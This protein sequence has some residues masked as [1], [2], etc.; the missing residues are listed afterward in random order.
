MAVTEIPGLGQQEAE[1]EAKFFR[2]SG[3]TAE[4]TSDGAGT[5][6]LTVTTPDAVAPG[7]A[8]GA[9]IQARAGKHQA[10]IDALIAGAK[11]HGLDPMGVLTIVS[12]ECEFNAADCNPVSSAAGLFQ[13]IDDTWFACGGAA[14]PGRGGIGNGQAAGAPVNVQI[15]IGCK[16][17]ADIAQKLK[18]KFGQDPDLTRI[19]MAHQQGLGGALKILEADPNAAIESIIG[20]AAARN[21]AFGGLTVAQTIAKFGRLVGSH[22]DEVRALVQTAPGAVPVTP[23]VLVTP[24]VADA[25]FAT[26]STRFAQS[27][28][29]TFARRNGQ[30]ITETVDPLRTRVLEYFALVGRPDITDTSADAWSAAFIS[31]VMNKSG[32][33]LT[34]FP[35]SAGHSRYILFG[36]ANRISNRLNASV[37]YFDRNEIVPRVGDLIGFSRTAS[38]TSRADLEK[39][40]PNKFFPSHTNLV[41]DVSPGL[42]KAIGGNVSNTIQI[43]NVKTGAGGHIDPSDHHFFVLRINIS[44]PGTPMA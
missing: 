15:E 42:I 13:F 12:I 31:F 6:K 22:E 30:V 17:L 20:A 23:P 34:D 39:L 5:F 7:P 14:F 36:L 43:T 24:P 2:D 28:M 8:D 27:E 19:Y 40:L 32:A 3:A 29:Q 10:V 37:V 11:A 21:N 4:I 33:A 9:D 18:A 38:V 16:F 44:A 25:S 35:I 41:V 26:T 1:D